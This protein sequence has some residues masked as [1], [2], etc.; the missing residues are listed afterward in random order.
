MHEIRLART[1]MRVRF[2]ALLRGEDEARLRA[3]GEEALD[4]VGR[5]ERLLSPFDP[6]SDLYRVNGQGFAHPVTVSGITAAFLAHALSLTE[7]TSGAFDLTATSGGAG[8]TLE[9]GMVRLPTSTT[10]L[11]PGGLAKGWALERAAELLVEAGVTDALLHGGTSSVV[12]LGPTLWPIAI[13]G[14]E[15]V[16]SLCGDALS[17]SGTRERAHIY[18]PATGQPIEAA[19]LVVVQAPSA[20]DAEAL[21]TALLVSGESEP[22]RGR[23]PA[24]RLW[25]F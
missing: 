10:R 16:V 8:F 23:F 17:V 7:A 6:A 9:G 4:E 5:M 14:T 1:A 11:D 15:L 2:E 25:M 19:R 22:L 20:T 12:A 18:D 24:A 13:A 21:S 3:A